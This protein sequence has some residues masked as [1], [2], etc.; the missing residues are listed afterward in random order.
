MGESSICPTLYVGEVGGGG[1][2][3][4]LYTQSCIV[5]EAKLMRALA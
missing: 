4:A 1:G 3:G 5:E 2:A